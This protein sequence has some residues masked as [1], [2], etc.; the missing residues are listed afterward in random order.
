MGFA[1][2]AGKLSY[3]F[4]ATIFSAKSKKA[5]LIAVSEEISEKSK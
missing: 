5:K 1:S 2:K 3:G 4:D